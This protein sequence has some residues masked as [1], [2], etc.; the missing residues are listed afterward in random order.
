MKKLLSFGASLLPTASFLDAV[1]T[2]GMGRPIPWVRDTIMAASGV[3]CYYLL[4]MERRGA[5]KRPDL[6]I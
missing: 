1:F 2:S 4:I 3:V 5:A 6:H